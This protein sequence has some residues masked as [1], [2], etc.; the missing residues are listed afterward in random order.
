MQRRA[1]RIQ[2]LLALIATFEGDLLAQT[3]TRV[4]VSTPGAQ[5]DSWS[6]GPSISP[7]GRFVA[8]ISGA[9][10]LVSGD[11]NG[12]SD[13][14]VHDRQTGATERVSVDS[15]GAQGN[16]DSYSPAISADGRYVAFISRADNL[17]STDTNGFAD[18]FVRDRQIGITSRVSVDSSG[19]QANADNDIG[20]A[21][22]SADGRFVVFPS[23]ASNLV[24]GD[25]NGISDIFMHDMLTGS[26]IR[27]SIASNGA[28]GNG[29]SYSAAISSDGR[30]VAF[31]S[32]ATN[33]FASDSNG[34]S[35]IFVRDLQAATTTLVSVSS[36]GTQGHNLSLV[37]SISGDGRYV[38]FYSYATDLVPGDTNGCGDVF[39]HD[40]QTGQTTRVSVDSNG[41]QGNGPSYK[42]SLSADG[43]FVAFT[44]DASNL[45]PGDTNL[46]SD[47][48]VHDALTGATA[49][50]S[51]DSHGAQADDESYFPCISAD[52]RYV[53]F[54][55]AATNLV[56]GDTNGSL[57]VFMYDS[58]GGTCGGGVSTYCMAK[59]NSQGCIPAVASTGISSQGG[60]DNFFVTAINVLNNKSGILLWGGAQASTPFFGGTL[61]IAPPII[62]TPLQ[63]SGGNPPPSDCSGTYSFHFSQA[64]MAS[65]F[66]SAGSTVYAQYWSRD[67]G[68]VFPNNI[69]L[70]N[71]LQF[72]ICP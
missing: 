55:S 45:V 24:A 72:T 21:C 22:I 58:I 23:I 1:V 50:V 68:F 71:G 36:S 2:L 61:C 37:P 27:V 54:H 12:A 10:N 41:M 13:V 4:S 66:L 32:N 47:I 18:V 38:S 43:R 62:R 8:F 40:R 70:T 52:G 42:S 69:G 16:G 60:P 29:G 56:Q 49:R 26:T 64:Y 19:A 3:T 39:V 20:F 34:G 51:V 63:S 35:D 48:F 30:Y 11:T 17:V 5:G 46:R 33:F 53:A 15:S 7:D 6:D 9:S 59:L 65:H 14:F 28:E 44:S 25:T 31:D 57:D 67:P